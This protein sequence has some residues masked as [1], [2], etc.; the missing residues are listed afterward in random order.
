M[1]ETKKCESFVCSHE[2]AAQIEEKCSA[3]CGKYVV[4]ER[5]MGRFGLV[6][7]FFSRLASDNDGEIVRLNIDPES[8][9]ASVEIDVP[10]LDLYRDGLNEF[11]DVLQH[12]DALDISQSD[13]DGVIIGATVNQTWEVAQ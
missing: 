5:N 4:N 13:S 8:I 7:D 10:P 6:Y 3:Y 2:L 12:V 1:S 9:N 11:V